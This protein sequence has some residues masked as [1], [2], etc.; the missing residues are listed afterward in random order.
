MSSTPSAEVE[1]IILSWESAFS[2]GIH[3]S[4]S[5]EG[6]GEGTGQV[7]WVV[8][9]RSTSSTSF[10]LPVCAPSGCCSWWL[11]CWRLEVGSGE[12]LF[13]VGANDNLAGVC[14]DHSGPDGQVEFA[15]S[16]VVVP[17]QIALQPKARGAQS[18]V[19]HCTWGAVRTVCGKWSKHKPEANP[20]QRTLATTTMVAVTKRHRHHHPTAT[21]E[22]V[23]R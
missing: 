1:C 18:D 4:Y 23:E 21:R 22:G 3:T 6:C 10:L 14:G 12:Y 5:T 8:S 20:T 7:C 13:V 17:H 16:P 11:W 19:W 9:F 2:V 15:G